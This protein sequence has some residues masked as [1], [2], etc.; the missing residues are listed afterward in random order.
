M[1]PTLSAGIAVVLI[2]GGILLLRRRLPRLRSSRQRLHT[3]P[4]VRLNDGDDH[5]PAPPVADGAVTG[6]PEAEDPLDGG[7]TVADGEPIT[8]PADASAPSK[9][10]KLSQHEVSAPDRQL[11]AEGRLS[12]GG[13]P[14]PGSRQRREQLAQLQAF[15]RRGGEAR[16]A[17]MEAALAW[18]DQ[19]CLPLLRRGLKDPDLRVVAL[20]A[21]G[22]E[23]FR[24]HRKKPASPQRRGKRLLRGA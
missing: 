4:V 5:T 6:A 2:G 21:Q 23:R 11:Q 10:V 15:Y 1:K 12:V 8:E 19:L 17:A 14:V 22:L 18:G 3:A 7:P 9:D 20:A 24:G 13:R 16:V